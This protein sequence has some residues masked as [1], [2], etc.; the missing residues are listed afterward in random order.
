MDQTTLWLIGGVIIAFVGVSLFIFAIVRRLGRHNQDM[1]ARIEENKT[2]QMAQMQQLVQLTASLEGRLRQMS[3]QAGKDREEMNRTL[4]ERLDKVSQRM[5]DSLEKNTKDTTASLGDLKS[6]LAVI[7]VAQKNITELSGQMM[8][9]QDILSNK[10]ARGA[11]GEIQLNDL[12]SQILPPSAY[13][14]QAPMGNGRRADCLIKLP[15]PPGSIVVDAKFPLES[16]HALRNA[17]DDGQFKLAAARFRAD[18]LKHVKDISDKYIIPGETAESAL[19]FL[20]SEAVYAELHASFPD[21]VEKSYRAKVWI[22]SPTTLMATLNTVRAVLKDARMREQAGVIQK[23]VG[24]LMEDVGR[25]DDRVGKLR[26]H[27][28]QAEKDIGLI[29]TSARKVMSR[30]EK[31]EGLQLEEAESPAEALE[32]VQG[33]LSVE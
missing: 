22:V 10:Q 26:V 21:V 8:G 31:I 24:V 33:K 4:A 15:N 16:Y 1:S 2:G 14:F 20:P 12:V 13:G 29:E 25:L 5:G 19:M 7:D 32:P 17:E 30:G 3:E 9:L 6:R 28:H 23:E 27:F 11:F 18:I